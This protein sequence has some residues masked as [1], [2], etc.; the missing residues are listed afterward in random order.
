MS[1]PCQG[2]GEAV[3]SRSVVL[4]G[5]L[6]DAVL[7]MAFVNYVWRNSSTT[8]NIKMNRFISRNCEPRKNLGVLTLFQ[9]IPWLLSMIWEPRRFIWSFPSDDMYIFIYLYVC[10]YVHIYVY[11]TTLYD[12]IYVNVYVVH[13]LIF[14][15]I[16]HNNNANFPKLP[17]SFS[18]TT[19]TDWERLSFF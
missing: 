2:Y 13:M 14:H 15:Y 16:S 4:M 6:K 7:Q 17:L 3:G 5:G 1:S 12:N 10:V 9:T 11:I 18:L 8:G 19:I